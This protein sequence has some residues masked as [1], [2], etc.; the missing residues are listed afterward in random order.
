MAASKP[1][2]QGTR[3]RSEV[4]ERNVIGVMFGD[5][6]EE[7]QCKIKEEMRREMEE[8]EATRMRERLACYQKTRGGVVQ[9]A[10]TSK[11]A[12]SKV[13]S[14]FP[15]P[16]ELVHLVD[17]SITSKY[18]ADLAQLTRVL[19]ED[20]CSTIDSFKHDLYDNLPRQIRSVLKDV[21]GE[22][23]GKQPIDITST[24]AL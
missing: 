17:V 19:A 20:V 13:N 1:S 16:E 8:I 2:G 24:P 23:Q 14:S 15:T 9:K 6:V 11:A 3:E 10:D 22:S 7:D 18:G 21:V 12:S 5:L 4:D